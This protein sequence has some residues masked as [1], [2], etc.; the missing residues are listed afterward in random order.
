[1]TISH[2]VLVFQLDGKPCALK[3]TDIQEIIHIEPITPI[4]RAP[5][6]VAGIINFRGNLLT[7]LD[8]A[9]R[10]FKDNK[11]TDRNQAYI[12]IPVVESW[13]VGLVV[14]QVEEIVSSEN[15]ELMDTPTAT[16]SLVNVNEQYCEGIVKWNT[17]ETEKSAILLDLKPLVKPVVDN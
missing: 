14:S 13:P 1:M 2:D 7:V 17:D 5:S 16:Q 11:I 3:I 15:L 10:L 9:E 4:P 8:P 12:L 6:Y